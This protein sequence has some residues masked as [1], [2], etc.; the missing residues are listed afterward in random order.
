[1][2]VVFELLAEYHFQD[3]YI[4]SV[5]VDKLAIKSNQ[6]RQRLAADTGLPLRRQKGTSVDEQRKAATPSSSS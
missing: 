1:M 2:D 4:C 5:V 3:K 6:W